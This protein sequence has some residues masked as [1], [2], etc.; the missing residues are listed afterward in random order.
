M[1][2]LTKT[3][4]CGRG[5]VL[6]MQRH[7]HSWKPP[8]R[9]R[10]DGERQSRHMICLC[11]DKARCVS[12]LRW[13]L[14]LWGIVRQLMLLCLGAVCGGLCW[15]SLCCDR[16]WV[17]WAGLKFN[18]VL[19][20]KKH[21]LKA[22]HW[23]M[24]FII[25]HIMQYY[26]ELSEG[27]NLISYGLLL[28]TV[29]VRNRTI[30]SPNYLILELKYLFNPLFSSSLSWVRLW[31]D[32]VIATITALIFD[33]HIIDGE[34]QGCAADGKACSFPPQCSDTLGWLYRKKLPMAQERQWFQAQKTGL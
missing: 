11:F 30:M 34:W 3:G 1:K 21:V 32:S 4:R 15:W 5:D 16:Y 18:V 31:S 7:Q 24:K 10:T 28:L 22:E 23:P 25:E 29:D 6:Y 19:A 12:L 33:L 14:L 17:A 13:L 2:M 26:A 9:W 20:L 8:W 27:H